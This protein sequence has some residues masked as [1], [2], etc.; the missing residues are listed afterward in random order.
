MMHRD[1]VAAFVREA[2]AAG[3]SPWVAAPAHFRLLW[4]FGIDAKPPLFHN[5]ARLA[6]IEGAL[7]GFFYGLFFLTMFTPTESLLCGL[8]V[9]VA[10][11]WVAGTEYELA[12]EGLEHIPLWD[13]Y[14]PGYSL[15]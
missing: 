14:I 5:T 12:K 8:W 10:F 13:D 15:Y 4:R 7:F 11:T 1:K 6:I 3:I 9:G 2:E